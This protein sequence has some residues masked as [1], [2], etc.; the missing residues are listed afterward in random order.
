MKEEKEKEDKMK[1]DKASLSFAV[2]EDTPDWSGTVRA[3]TLFRD[4]PASLASTAGP[5]L[6]TI[7]TSIHK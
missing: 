4:L 7:T 2:A 1:K 5:Q 6:K 3:T